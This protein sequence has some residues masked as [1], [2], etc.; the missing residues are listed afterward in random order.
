MGTLETCS[1]D[2]EA[3]LRW[4]TLRQ[5]NNEG[6]YQ[7]RTNKLVDSCYSF[8]NGSIPA[9]LLLGTKGR[10]SA[11]ARHSMNGILLMD[12]ERLQKY[13]LSCC[14]QTNGGLRDKPGKSRDNY[15]TCYALSGLS[16]AQQYGPG[17]NRNGEDDK[18]VKN[19]DGENEDEDE[20]DK[21]YVY[22][23]EGN[24]LQPTHPVYNITLDKVNRSKLYFDT[25]PCSH[26]VLSQII[27]SSTERSD[28]DAESNEEADVEL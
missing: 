21:C 6:G 3:V 15:H 17:W 4:V 27:S 24:R 12:Q 22:G 1:I 23:N 19:V 25:L 2:I 10:M 16:V 20:D 14:Q 18:N 7:G 13:V 5:M 11:E 9:V 8:W 28:D 26:Q